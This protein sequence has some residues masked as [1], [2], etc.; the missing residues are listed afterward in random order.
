MVG[1][2]G[3]NPHR[4]P[5]METTLSYNYSSPL[6]LKHYPTTPAYMMSEASRKARLAFPGIAASNS[7]DEA[8]NPNTLHAILLQGRRRSRW[9]PSFVYQGE[10]LDAGTGAPPGAYESLAMAHHDQSLAWAG[11]PSTGALEEAFFAQA[12]T[13]TS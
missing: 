8:N 6:S 1:A 5:L 9:T 2:Y 13:P 12:R 4:A 10:D 3:S 7:F 11:D